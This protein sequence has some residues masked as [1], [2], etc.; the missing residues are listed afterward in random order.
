MLGQI[1]NEILIFCIFKGKIIKRPNPENSLYG[2]DIRLEGDAY[3]YG[4]YNDAVIFSYQVTGAR[5]GWGNAGLKERLT[6]IAINLLKHKF[7]T[8]MI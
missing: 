2:E 7:L 1:M 4:F 6:N 8:A 3:L 5:N